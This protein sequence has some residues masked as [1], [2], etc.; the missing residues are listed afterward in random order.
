ME[1][2]EWQGR[3]KGDKLI[4]QCAIASK[5]F[6]LRFLCKRAFVKFCEIHRKTPVPEESLLMVLSC[7]IWESFKN[8]FFNR[9]LLAASVAFYMIKFL[10]F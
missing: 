2:D 5:A 7:E 3:A 1:L 10:Y 4:F 6:A 9:T 8:T